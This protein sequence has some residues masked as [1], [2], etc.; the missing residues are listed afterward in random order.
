MNGVSGKFTEQVRQFILNLETLRNNIAELQTMWTKRF[1]YFTN[2]NIPFLCLLI[3]SVLL[4]PF[5]F[6]G[7]SSKQL[8]VLPRN[9][10]VFTREILTWLN[11]VAEPKTFGNFILNKVS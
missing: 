6:E 5:L 4:Q 10:I 11:E 8:P 9:Q 1:P 2:G 3:M 7:K